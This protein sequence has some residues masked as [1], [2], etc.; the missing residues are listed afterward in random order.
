MNATQT[1][2]LPVFKADFSAMTFPAD[3]IGG[4]VTQRAVRTPASQ[5]VTQL[6]TVLR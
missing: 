5:A 3:Y 6:L 1:T 2:Q 4:G